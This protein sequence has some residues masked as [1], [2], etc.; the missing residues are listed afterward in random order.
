MRVAI[1]V[2]ASRAIGTGH[3]RRSLALGEAL[4][5]CGA[6]VRFVTRS[7]GLDSAGM[8][9]GAGFE[10]TA[11]LGPPGSVFAPDPAIPHSAWGEVPQQRDLE[12]SVAALADFAPEWLVVDSYAFDARW[13]RGVANGLGCRIAVIDDL[14]DRKLAC[15]VLIDHTF[16]PD[17]RAK[18]GRVLPDGARLFGGPRFALLGPA[19]PAAPRHQLREE[20]R[21]IGVF[22]GGADPEDFSGRVLEALDLAGF[23][24]E[25]EVVTTSANPNLPALRARTD[26]RPSTTL[27][28]DLPDLAGFFAR[29][30]LQIGAGGG[31]SWER[32]CIGV[33]TLLL[34][35][36]PNQMTVA[37]SLA[38][39]GIADYAP[40]AAPRKLAAKLA[41]LIADAQRRAALAERSRRLVDGHGAERVALGLLAAGLAVRPARA[42]D[43]RLLFEWRNAPE[44]RRW[45]R[46][47]GAIAW[48]GHV[49]WLDR[50]LADPGRI[51]LVGEIGGRPVG[52]IR[53]DDCGN[54]SYE[55][56][57]HLDPDLA[58]LGLGPHLLAAG[59][60]AAD[61]ARIV[62]EVLPDNAP[63]QALF[64]RSGY[65]RLDETH[66]EKRRR[67][68]PAA[69][70]RSGA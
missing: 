23:S 43:A 64:A 9:A 69:V 11:L 1:R 66:F 51:L 34:V 15:D 8:I 60:V 32:C 26:R 47:K 62:A 59:E 25:I 30:D 28:V 14:A 18:Y 17:H 65:D 36:A 44:N 27:S 22:M 46:E 35:I 67:P 13:H 37:P 56:S 40:D 39:A 3:L 45:M 2:D 42:E 31:A 12:E 7:L 19:Y 49:A 68:A 16:A 4:R 5:S 63:S 61:P 24:G 38:E 58:G 6:Q 55:V 57:L 33:P 70:G 41:A 21:S 54:E 20:V 52:A 50:V 48:E 29:H 10:G 53:F